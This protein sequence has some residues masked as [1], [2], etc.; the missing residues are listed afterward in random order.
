LHESRRLESWRALVRRT[1]PAT[2]R[3]F[4]PILVKLHPRAGRRDWEPLFANYVLVRIEVPSQEWLAVRACPGVV[5][6]LGHHG[7]PSPLPDDFV[8]RLRTR[9]ESI[10][11]TGG[12]PA[13]SRGQRVTIVS[14]VF[15]QY[16]AI[17]D[18]RLSPTG[19]SRVLLNLLHRLVPLDLPED[20]LRTAS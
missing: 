7:E 2:Q 5:Y 4:L 19:R 8:P 20:Y 3:A 17:F 6:F 16:D 10:N 1:H 18:R 12:V 14:G 13:F 11:R 9:L 15:S